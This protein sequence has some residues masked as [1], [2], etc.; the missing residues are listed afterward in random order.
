[1]N[2][3]LT[4]TRHQLLIPLEKERLD[5]PASIQSALPGTKTLLQVVRVL[6]AGMSI[7]VTYVIRM[8]GYRIKGTK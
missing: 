6:A 3:R 1:M 2:F 8:P 7:Y 5:A 4:P